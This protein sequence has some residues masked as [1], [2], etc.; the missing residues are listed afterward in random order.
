MAGGHPID[1]PEP[2]RSDGAPVEPIAA[3]LAALRAELADRAR[4]D[5]GL[6]RFVSAM[7]AAEGAGGPAPAPHPGTSPEGL[8]RALSAMAGP[9]VLIR[10]AGDAASALAWRPLYAGGAEPADAGQGPPAA[11][12]IAH[13]LRCEGNGGSV[14]VSVGLML[15]PPGLEYPLHN[16]SA[17][18]VYVTLSGVVSV[19]H[20][21]GGRPFALSDGAHSITP[22]NRPHRI[23]TGPLPALLVFIWLDALDGPIWWWSERDDGGWQRTRWHRLPGTPW[24]PAETVQVTARE[25]AE[26]GEPPAIRRGSGAD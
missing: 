4:C 25:L 9:A 16:H 11:V 7:A 2:A 12:H 1:P 3:F 21:L 19:A 14:A 5:E 15:F 13:A 26:A 17:P 20:G 10:T 23:E 8:N 24:R 6:A 22:S 18:E